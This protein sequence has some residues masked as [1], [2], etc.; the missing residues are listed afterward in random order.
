[1]DDRFNLREFLFPTSRVNQR[2]T[3]RAVEREQAVARERQGLPSL[4]SL[5]ARMPA[6]DPRFASTF[7]N[8][9]LRDMGFTPTE[10]T[11]ILNQGVAGG[12]F[13][14]MPSPRLQATPA[15]PNTDNTNMPA[16]TFLNAR[17]ESDAYRRVVG[18]AQRADTNTDIPPSMA[19]ALDTP[20][21]Q[22]Y[23][24]GVSRGYR[25]MPPERAT[26]YL[27]TSGNPSNLS[28][29]NTLSDDELRQAGFGR[30]EIN[31]IR[32]RAPQQE[33]ISGRNPRA[34]VRIEQVASRGNVEPVSMSPV[35]ATT[36]RATP[37]Y[38]DMVA[39]AFDRR[40]RES[41]DIIP[42]AELTGP[43]AGYRTRAMS[44]SLRRGGYGA[45]LG[46]FHEQGRAWDL[47][48]VD[49]NGVERPWTMRRVNQA[50]QDFENNTGLRVIRPQQTNVPGQ[51]GVVETESTYVS[52]VHG[53]LHLV[54]ELP[55]E[56]TSLEGFGAIGSIEDPRIALRTIGLAGSPDVR[57]QITSS[58]PARPR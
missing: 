28:Y 21:V 2:E 26:A 11:Q 22:S 35:S 32:Q 10:I 40:Q 6:S 3:E 55:E 42:N 30:T 23:M 1:M 34:G 58:Q 29:P 7:T 12:R 53:Q 36:A 51:I 17:P 24:A 9:Q 8:S 20:Q 44:E 13:G 48:Y 50:I 4:E 37:G 52:P 15:R 5:R 57:A 39:Q 25:P 31:L 56:R 38:L 54:W 45:E 46:G 16:S 49:N 27:A 19:A 43:R 14:N 18:V 47:R 41:R 33:F